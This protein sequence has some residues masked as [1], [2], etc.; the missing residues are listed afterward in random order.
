[1]LPWHLGHSPARSSH[2]SG[3]HCG[4]AWSL[5]QLHGVVG[6]AHVGRR[7]ATYGEAKHSVV[8]EEW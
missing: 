4:A 1:V 3:E 8:V 7:P 2:C 6:A 5:A